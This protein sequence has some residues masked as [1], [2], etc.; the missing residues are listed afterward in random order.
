MFDDSV[1]RFI[2]VMIILTLT[3]G[4][5]YLM[6]MLLNAL[7]QRLS[8]GQA[9]VAD[10]LEDLRHRIEELEGVVAD[11]DDR[12]LHRQ[13]SEM[14]ERLE[15]A[16]RLLSNEENRALLPEPSDEVTAATGKRGGANG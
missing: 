14:E 3:G 2:G 6:I 1:M 4:G 11:T 13:L 16:E 5:I 9:Q 8:G 12:D 10:E 7:Q 15:F